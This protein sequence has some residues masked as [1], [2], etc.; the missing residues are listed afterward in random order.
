MAA[1]PDI[2]ESTGKAGEASPGGLFPPG[3]QV[4]FSIVPRRPLLVEGRLMGLQPG[5]ESK[6]FDEPTPL[7]RSRLDL[8]SWPVVGK[9]TGGGHPR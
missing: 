4:P 7:W 1:S 5:V 2:G 3:K 9:S 6:L 8:S